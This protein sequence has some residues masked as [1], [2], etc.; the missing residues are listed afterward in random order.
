[1]EFTKVSPQ[2]YIKIISQRQTKLNKLLSKKT[3]CAI[4]PTSPICRYENLE[5]EIFNWV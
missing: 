2:G 1:M 5:Y 4:G 3:E